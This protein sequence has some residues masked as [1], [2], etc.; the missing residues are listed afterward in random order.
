MAIVTRIACDKAQRFEAPT[1]P[2]LDI[3]TETHEDI[4][5]AASKALAETGWTTTPGGYYCPRH[6]PALTVR[7]EL[8]L[9]KA[10]Y[11]T[12]DTVGVWRAK[13]VSEDWPDA[14]AGVR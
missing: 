6:N 14:E 11:D 5:A 1:C 9:D 7:A 4:P 12:V 3:A 2:Y 13:H 10:R 8:L